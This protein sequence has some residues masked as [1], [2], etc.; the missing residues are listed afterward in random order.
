MSCISVNLCYLIFKIFTMLT[1]FIPILDSGFQLF[2]EKK[3]CNRKSFAGRM[4]TVNMC[5]LACKKKGGNLF[6]YAREGSTE[7]NSDGCYCNCHTG[8][9]DGRCQDFVKGASYDLYQI[10]KVF[11]PR[12]PNIQNK[13]TGKSRIQ[14]LGL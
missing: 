10:G 2:A 4:K 9:K 13:Q 6:A 7:C 14:V 1:Y 8:S 3:S 11:L 5:F 12:K